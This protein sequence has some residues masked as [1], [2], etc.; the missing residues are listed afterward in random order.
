MKHVAEK[1]ITDTLQSEKLELK[2]ADFTYTPYT[3]AGRYQMHGKETQIEAISKMITGLYQQ[4]AVC[5]DT[6]IAHLLLSGLNNLMPGDNSTGSGQ[7]NLTALQKPINQ[8]KQNH[9]KP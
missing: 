5:G 9:Q 3:F 4:C 7:P 6:D 8:Y 1:K 2:K